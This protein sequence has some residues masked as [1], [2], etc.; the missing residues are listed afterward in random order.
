MS[1]QEG[2]LEAVVSSAFIMELKLKDF[3]ELR[4]L[5][6]EWSRSRKNFRLIHHTFSSK[7]YYVIKESDWRLLQKIRGGEIK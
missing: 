4:E 2:D 5:L 3:L 7:K 6:T 1:L